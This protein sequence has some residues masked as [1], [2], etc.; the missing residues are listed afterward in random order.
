MVT[1]RNLERLREHARD[2]VLNAFWTMADE[3]GW[4]DEA[5]GLIRRRELDPYAVA[6]RMV[7][8][9]FKCAG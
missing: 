1:E 4:L 8:R 5:R 2:R 9:A 3:H 6:D 7:T